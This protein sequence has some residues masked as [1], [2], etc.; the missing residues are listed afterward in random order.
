M[1]IIS[2]GSGGSG[3]TNTISYTIQYGDTLSGIA[4]RYNTTV[5]TLAS[6][7]KIS[8]PNLIYA[9]E[10]IQIPI[11]SGGG[12]EEHDC[13]HIIYTVKYGDTLSEIAYRYGTTVADLV[14]LNNIAN[15]NLIYP[16]Q[17]LRISG[18]CL[19]Q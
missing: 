17:K 19:C 1:L 14:E 11:N 10:T 9:G 16:N 18:N 8:N 5:N 13:G 3:N 12:Q 6:L 7:N 15:P 4:Y 2:Q